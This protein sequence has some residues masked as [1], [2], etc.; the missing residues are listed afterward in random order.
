MKVLALEEKYNL[1]KVIEEEVKEFTYVDK[2][3]R[4][5][6]KI[7][8]F[9]NGQ[10]FI[11]DIKKK[12][13]KNNFYAPLIYNM[14]NVVN[15]KNSKRHKTI[16]F[17]ENEELADLINSKSKT[18][19]ATTV[20]N[21]IDNLYVTENVSKIFK[22]TDIIIASP[23]DNAH[24]RVYNELF[25]VAHSIRIFNYKYIEN[26]EELSKEECRVAKILNSKKVSK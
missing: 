9:A 10:D 14:S 16:V 1:L 3:N 23:Y 12:K 17:V 20:F 13:E 25:E 8:K 19:V 11:F 4:N 5:M 24:F 18:L 21:G 22:D 15:V 26:I 7:Y 2:F 6:Y